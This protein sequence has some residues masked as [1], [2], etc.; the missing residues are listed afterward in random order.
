VALVN[1]NNVLTMATAT[2]SGVVPVLILK[3]GTQRTTGYEALRANIA[4]AKAIAET[5]KT[6]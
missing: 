3:E 5:V 1:N 6:S 2:P 4:A